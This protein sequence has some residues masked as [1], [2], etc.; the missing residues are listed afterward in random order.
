MIVLV[1]LPENEVDTID[2]ASSAARQFMGL[3]VAVCGRA[4]Q[5]G[6]RCQ[7]PAGWGVPDVE[8]GP[9]V[10]HRRPIRSEIAA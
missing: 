2:D 4:K 1:D 7:R 8:V 9:C 5:D 3:E 6:E 10:E